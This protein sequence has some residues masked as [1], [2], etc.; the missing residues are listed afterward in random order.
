ML[1][2][3]G[4]KEYTH[5]L[6]TRTPNS[7][8]TLI[9]TMERLKSLV[10]SGYVWLDLNVVVHKANITE[11][12]ALVNLAFEHGVTHILFLRLIPF[13]HSEIS[14]AL[15]MDRQASLD[16]IL[17]IARLREKY[18]DLIYLE[19]GIS[20]GPNFYSSRIWNYLL[21]NA[22]LGAFWHYCLAM[23]AWIALHPETKKIFPCMAS[24][25]MPEFYLGKIQLENDVLTFHYNDVGNQLLNWH[26]DWGVK[27]KKEC[28]PKNCPFSLLCHGGCRAT[29]VANNQKTT[30]EIDWFSP[31]PWCQTQLLREY[32]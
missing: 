19:L 7:F 29:A 4:A 3:H 27:A 17:E 20:W 21:A 16:A 14:N 25:G 24:S 15:Y 31:F 26:Q 32:L 5:E 12:D 11:L 6:I 23:D 2:L 8:R 1:S 30:G 13:S 22:K 10:F 28:S 18:Q 9:Q